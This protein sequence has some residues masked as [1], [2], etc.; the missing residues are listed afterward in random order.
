[1]AINYG[2]VKGTVTGHLRNADDDHYQILVR[3]GDASNATLFRIA[4]NVKSSA[5]HAP[6][7][8][9]F[10]HLTTLPPTLLSGLAVLAPGFTKVA[11]QPGGLALDYLR[12][13][14]F[15]VSTM[16]PVPADASVG[17]NDLKDK[18]EAAMV[19]AMAK[20][21]TLIHAFGSRWGPEDGKPDQYFKFVP[22]NGIHDIHM[23][24][25]NSGGYAGDNGTYQDGGLVLV[26]PDATCEGFFFAFQSQSF[27]TDDHGNPIA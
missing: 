4:S 7:V 5:P 17:H 23:N 10:K 26:Y 18:L 12:G 8:V 2:I 16:T 22:G 21:G 9:L 3:S 25:G 24:Q 6:S 13:G 20:D 11:S 19:A 27:H 1:M 15:D 14:L